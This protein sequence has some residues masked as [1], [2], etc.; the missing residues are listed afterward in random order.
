M[1]KLEAILHLYRTRKITEEKA[2]QYAESRNL[3]AT[4]KAELKAEIEK[5]KNSE[6]DPIVEEAAEVTTDEN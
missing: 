4:E 2:Y 6:S 5:I 1:T 3:P